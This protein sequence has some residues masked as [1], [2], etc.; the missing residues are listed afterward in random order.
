MGAY[1]YMRKSFQETFKTRAQH[2]RRRMSLWRKQRTVER[3]EHSSDLPRARALGYKAKRGIYLARVRIRRGKR[4]R[5]KPDQGRKPG[6]SVKRINPGRSLSYYAMNK[7]R[8]KFPNL[9]P[10]AAYWV[11]EDGMF[12]YFEVIM[13]DKRA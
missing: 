3:I 8:T 11:G 6:R 7:T 9:V 2:L 4:V 10:K 12:K 1:S 13:R 5:D